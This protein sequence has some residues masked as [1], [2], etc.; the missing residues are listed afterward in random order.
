M[1]F[2]SYFFFFMLCMLLLGLQFP[3]DGIIILYSIL[4]YSILNTDYPSAKQAKSNLSEE[5]QK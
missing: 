4:F 1:L 5:D 2:T 3:H